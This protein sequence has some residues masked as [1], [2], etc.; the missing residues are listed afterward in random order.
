MKLNKRRQSNTMVRTKTKVRFLK[1]NPNMLG[2]KIKQLICVDWEQ[3]RAGFVNHRQIFK[4]K[5]M[6]EYLNLLLEDNNEQEI[7]FRQSTLSKCCFL[8]PLVF[9]PFDLPGRLGDWT[10]VRKID[11]LD[12]K[13]NHRSFSL[14][15]HHSRRTSTGW[16]CW[17]I[18]CRDANSSCLFMHD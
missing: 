7:Y 15:R 2:M 1:E 6:H 17:K 8:S 3:V 13:I 16:T 9:L 14:K 4:H 18:L 10:R 5:C 11:I 12:A